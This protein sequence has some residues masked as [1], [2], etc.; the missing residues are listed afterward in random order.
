MQTGRKSAAIAA[1]LFIFS[2]VTAANGLNLNGFG[3]RAVAMGGAFVGLADDYSSIFWNP[4]GIAQFNQTV[5]GMSGELI[6][7]A[8]TYE[9][10]MFG[11]KFVDAEMKHKIYPAGLAGF[12][13]PLSDK[14]AAGLGIYTPSGLGASWEG[15]DFASFSGGET[16]KWESYVGVISISPAVAYKISEKVFAGASLNI[17][18]GF[19]N[20]DRHAGTIAVPMDEPPYSDIVDLGQY[21]EESSG[22]GVSGTFGVLIK[23]AEMF[24]FGAT[25]RTPSKMAMSGKAEIRRLQYMGLDAESDFE[26]DV[27]SPLWA[28]GGIAFHPLR[29]LTLSFDAQYTNWSA[30]DVLEAEFSNS[31][32]QAMMDRSGRDKMELHW[33]DAVQL[34]FGVEYQW[35]ETFIRGGYYRDPAPAPDETMNVLIPSY[36]FNVLTFGLGRSCAGLEIGAAI[37]YLMGEEREI[38]FNSESGQPGVYNMN[39]LTP[40]LSIAYQW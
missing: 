39:I 33:E 21:S 30:L 35:G 25:V 37:E 38:A 23:P 11:F 5:M 6:I 15:A 27:I 36:T 1:F 26:R 29:N 14:L 17:N 19:F 18:C 31:Y 7:P 10:E 20:I 4:A 16:Y 2:S 9:L 40:L 24:S 28:A 3:A 32:W 22:W 13:Y 34:R 8:S 12:V